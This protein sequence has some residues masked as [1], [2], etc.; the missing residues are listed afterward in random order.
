MMG[1]DL[2]KLIF[3][4]NGMTWYEFRGN[5]INIGGC[6]C[7]VAYVNSRNITA[8]R[9]RYE[10]IPGV[11]LPSAGERLPKVMPL[12]LDETAALMKIMNSNPSTD[13]WFYIPSE[14]D[15]LLKSSASNIRECYI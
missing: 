14:P 7:R 1:S 15:E 9:K 2:L 10:S 13:T 11:A 6:A 12:T 8:A 3:I 5:T 4:R